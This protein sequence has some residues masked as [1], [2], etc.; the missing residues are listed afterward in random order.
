MRLCGFSRV[1]RKIFYINQNILYEAEVCRKLQHPNIVRLLETFD[2]AKKL[3]LVFDLVAGGEL[4]HDIQ[5]LQYYSEAL[6]SKCMQEILQAVN[7]FHKKGVVHRD[8]KAENILLTRKTKPSSI[9]IA[10]FGLAV[11][12]RGNERENFGYAGTP[13]YMAPEI[14]KRQSYGKPVDMWS[15]GVICKGMNLKRIF[16]ISL[17]LRS[18]HIPY[19]V[20]VADWR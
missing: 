13:L 7:F 20:S 14:L 3:Y 11:E 8:L 4:F 9:K 18:P 2:E 19:S 6:A 10:D 15:C 1:I 17:N 16:L 12:V 5:N